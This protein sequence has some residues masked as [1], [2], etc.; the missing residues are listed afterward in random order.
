MMFSIKKS[1]WAALLLLACPLLLVAWSPSVVGA[2]DP[3]TCGLRHRNT[4][5]SATRQ[6]RFDFETGDLQERKGIEVKFDRLIRDQEFF[7]NQ[8]KVKYDKQGAYY[9]NTL[10]LSDDRRT[11]AMSGVLESQVF[12]LKGGTVSFLVG[13]WE[14]V[15]FDGFRADGGIDEEATLA[16]AAA[17]EQQLREKAKQEKLSALRISVTRVRRAVQD[18]MQTFGDRYPR[19]REFLSTLDDIE[20]RAEEAAFEEAVRLSSQMESLTHEALI[21]NPLVGDQPILYVVRPQ[22]KEDHHSTATMFQTSEINSASFLGASFLKSIDFGKGGGVKTLIHVPEGIV[23]DPE[24]D[25]DGKRVLFSMR[26]NASDDYHVFEMNA[27]GTGLKQLTFG[28]GVSDIDPMYLPSGEIVFSSTREPK[29]CQCNRHI[30]ANLFKMDADGANI[31]QIGRNTLFEG[32]PS[33]MP[34]GRILYDRWE[35]V[36]KHFGPAFGLWTVNPDGTNQ[37]L[38]YGNNAWSPG[39]ILDARIIPGANS[40]IATFGSCHDRPWGAIVIADRGKGLDGLEPIIKSWPADINGFLRIKKPYFETGGIDYFKGVSPK[41]EDPY[42][43]SDKYFL[44]SRMIEGEEMGIF[45]LDIFGNEILLRREAPGCF[46]PMPISSRYRPPVIPSRVD[47]STSEGFFYVVDVYRGYG[48]EKVKRGT[49]KYL[50]IVEA[51]PKLF[52]THPCWNIDAQQGP[53]MNWNCTNNKRI[54]GDVPIEPDGSAYFALPADKFVFFQAL[55]ENGMMIQSMRSG[56]TV[57]PGEIGGCIGCHEGRLTGVPNRPLPAA[58]RRLPS[59]IEPWYGPPRDFDY[60]TELQPV[61]DRHCVRCHDFGK[62]EGEKLN[63]AGDLG[64]AF[65]TSYLELRR[66]SA[67]RWFPDPPGAEKILVKAVDD[68][69]AEFLPPYSWGSHRSKLVDLIREERCGVK[70]DRE[71]FD[72]IVTWIDMNAPYYGSYASAYPDNAFGRSPL[73]DEQLKR[74]SQL[75]GQKI[76]TQQSEMQGSQISFTRPE[77]SPCLAKF[78]DKKD[79]KY[80]EALAIIQAGKEMLAGRPRADMPGFRLVGIERERRQKY[81]RLVQYE[82]QARNAILEGKRS[83]FRHQD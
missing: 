64:L 44:C 74:L 83:Y 20:R 73:N 55:D 80:R 68:G 76:G 7:H 54:L 22:Y 31:Q 57:R 48:M 32:Q 62:P 34:D 21:A 38:Y 9:L 30:M 33:L 14:H 12:I 77:M 45:L 2:D 70:L 13:G 36:D 6:L 56:T 79:P 69:P 25:F 37:A 46:D 65:N 61:F 1:Q 10:E 78:K 5:P 19:G 35:Y 53:A 16:R 67:V 75:T 51:P 60:L 27:D 42:P 11:D 8:P 39:A 71:S 17:R 59:K 15:T 63:L 66:K 18:L 58:M 24:V 50:R 81:D 49:I 40:F 23:R 47:L 72:R 28:E 26:K 4:A 52:W 41:Y 3:H 43:L 29:Y 82:R